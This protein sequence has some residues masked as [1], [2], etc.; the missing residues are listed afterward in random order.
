LY[1]TIQTLPNTLHIR[2]HC[3]FE[4]AVVS[5]IGIEIDIRSVV[6]LAM[7][8]LL[9]IAHPGCP[10]YLRS[11]LERRVRSLPSSF[12]LLHVA[13]EVFVNADVFQGLVS[14]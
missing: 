1:V 8:M 14:D 4:L 5:I 2:C 6:I 3:D 10:E 13:G 7:A 11:E 9:W 12:L